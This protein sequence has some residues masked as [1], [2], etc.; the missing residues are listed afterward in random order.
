MA[1]TQGAGTITVVTTKERLHKLV[2]ELTEQEADDALRY[3]AERHDDP[4]IAAFRDAPVD[5]EPVSAADE[6]ALAEVRADR[7]A[8]VARISYAEIKRK[9]ASA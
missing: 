1:G 3:L 9:H 5:D 4:V 8:G 7:A 6:R 2:D